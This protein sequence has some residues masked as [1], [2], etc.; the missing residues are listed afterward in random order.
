MVILVNGTY[1]FV[2][3]SIIFLSYAYDII[4]VT[5]TDKLMCFMPLCY[6]LKKKK[7]PK[8]PRGCL[9]C[10]VMQI[11]KKNP[12]LWVPNKSMKIELMFY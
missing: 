2:L 10:K 11:Q 8:G 9:I 6:K 3:E 12:Y 1:H 4:I 7:K 5:I